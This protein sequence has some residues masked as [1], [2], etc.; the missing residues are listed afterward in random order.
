MFKYVRYGIKGE[1]F[2]LK[3]G[4][5]DNST[6][7]HGFMVSRYSNVGVDVYNRVFGAETDIR[8]GALGIE[9]F[10]NDIAWGRLY[11]GRIY[12]DII[13]SFLQAGVTGIYDYNP[14]KD[15]YGLTG[16]L[17]D[18]TPLVAY[19]ADLGISLIKTGLLS[20][21]VYADYGIFRDGGEGF[22][23]PGIMGKVA[24]FD[25]QLE[26]RSM[27]SNF[28]AGLFDYAYEDSRPALLP[29]A[30]A[31]GSKVFSASWAR[32]LYPGLI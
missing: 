32:V 11:A 30:G 31:R 29:A 9:G 3:L 16:K 1:P 24:F 20:V 12:Y 14:A 10:C 22:A 28:V 17:P 2:Y 7:G 4:V 21:L 5:L 25:Y 15:K 27:Q 13:P 8:L 26:Y 23:A 18:Q 6:L 19:G